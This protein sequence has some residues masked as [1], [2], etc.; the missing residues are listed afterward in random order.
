MDLNWYRPA[1]HRYF[2]EPVQ[3]DAE[4]ILQG[5][6]STLVSQPSGLSLDVLFAPADHGAHTNRAQSDFA[7][8]EN[9]LKQAKESYD[10][11]IVDSSAIFPTNRTM[12]DPVMLSR[13]VEGVILVVA[14]G[15][16]RKPSVRRAQKTLEIAGANIAGILTNEPGESAAR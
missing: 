16:S 4:Q 5:D 15:I 12:M 9:L 10:L 13:E 11:I 1:L 6:L 7:L 8:V 14:K 2:E 3:H